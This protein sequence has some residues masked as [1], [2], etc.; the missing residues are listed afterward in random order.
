[1]PPPHTGRSSEQLSRI[2]VEEIA[3][4]GPSDLPDPTHFAYRR[5]LADVALAGQVIASH[6]AQPVERT[7]GI[8]AAMH[9]E[10]SVEAALVAKLAPGDAFLMLDDSMGWTWGYGGRDRRVGYIRTDALRD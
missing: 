3:L 2:S 9:A 8:P 5:D 7:V 1:M 10:P 6:Y 4:N